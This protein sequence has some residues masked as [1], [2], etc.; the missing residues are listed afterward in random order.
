[1]LVSTTT[2]RLC[3]PFFVSSMTLVYQIPWAC[4]KVLFTVVN[5][6]LVIHVA[7]LYNSLG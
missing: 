4:I 6:T 2:E 3:L 5:F 1:M 7:E